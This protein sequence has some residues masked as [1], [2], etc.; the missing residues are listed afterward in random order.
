MINNGVSN[1]SNEELLSIILKTGTKDMSVKTLSSYILSYLKN[2]SNLKD[3]TYQELKKIKGVGDA[4][5]CSLLALG[6]LAKRINSEIDTL[7]GI[8]L[9]STEKVYKYYKNKIDSFQEHFYCIYLD[10]TNKVIKEKLLFIGTA[11]YS[12]VHPRDVFKEAYLLN[13]SN[14]ICVHNHPS[15]EVNPSKDDILITNRL[16]EVGQLTG[17]KILDHIIVSENDYYSFLENGKI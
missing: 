2:I 17:V 15:G 8:K 14:I 13:A 11:N 6:E 4:K 1:L 12:L 3:I 10:A 5:A 9:D 7:V 16:I